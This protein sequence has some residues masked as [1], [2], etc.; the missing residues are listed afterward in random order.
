[1]KRESD[2]ESDWT[3]RGEVTQSSPRSIKDL[4]ALERE[5]VGK[6][7]GEEHVLDI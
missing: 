1:M 3:D 2:V 7:K 6:S 4:V 5:G